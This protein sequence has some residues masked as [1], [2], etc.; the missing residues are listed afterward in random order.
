MNSYLCFWLGFSAVGIIGLIPFV[1][2]VSKAKKLSGWKETYEREF[3]KKWK[4]LKTIKEIDGFYDEK[5]S[6]SYFDRE[7][8]L[9]RKAYLLI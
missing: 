7:F 4:E 1:K 3:N 9:E 5:E 2:L 8:L 6:G